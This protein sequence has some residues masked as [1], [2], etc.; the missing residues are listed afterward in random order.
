MEGDEHSAPPLRIPDRIFAVGHEP[1]GVRVTPYHKPHDIRQ[2]LNTLDPKEVHTITGSPFGKLVEIAEKP[3]FS[4]C[5]DRIIISKKL[6][7]V[8]I[9]TEPAENNIIAEAIHFTNQTTSF[10]VEVSFPLT[11]KIL[12]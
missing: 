8:G 2:I 7:H 6:H 12:Y 11:P 9:Q 4:G 5:F 10:T 3:S 1:V